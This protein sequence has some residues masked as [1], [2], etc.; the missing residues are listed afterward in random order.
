M[1]TA[2]R[3]L[4][5]AASLLVLGLASSGC[6]YR[7]PE[8]IVIGAVVPLTGSFAAEGEY[9]RNGAAL[10]VAEINAAGGV[11][12]QMIRVIYEDSQSDVAGGVPAYQK[13]TNSDH[14]VA[15]LAHQSSGVALAA[16]L[17]NRNRSVLINCGAHDPRIRREGGAYVFNLVPDAVLEARAMAEYAATTLHLT[18]A[19]TVYLENDVGRTVAAAF[20]EAFIAHGG[21]IVAQEMVD[22]N[23]DE[24]ALSVGRLR[25]VHPE[26]VF[27][28][29]PSGTAARVLGVSGETGFRPRWLTDASFETENVRGAVGAPADGVVYTFPRAFSA[30]SPRSQ[31]FVEAYRARFGF[32]PESVAAT[33]YDGLFAL[34]G[35]IDAAGGT[36]GDDIA[37]GLPL[38]PLDGVTGRIDLSESKFVTRP[39]EF[40]T[41]SGGR[42]R[43]V[44]PGK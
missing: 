42:V 31:A 10:A 6:R 8:A 37:R 43:V 28:S 1:L 26:A 17:A 3:G 39:M 21:R 5:I 34:K 11:R 23:K 16:G 35:A 33:F 18:V 15:T 22:K 27:F 29:M 9:A 32:V 4:Q 19:A 24:T 38:A 7:A 30:A 44:A 36:S 14:V 41:I 2:C 20:A 25:A 12:G 13:L 40:R